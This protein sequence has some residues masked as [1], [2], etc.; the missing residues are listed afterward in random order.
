MARGFSGGLS[1]GRL[2]FLFAVLAAAG[3]RAAWAETSV[4][5][6]DH[7]EIRAD[8][9][10]VSAEAVSRLALVM[11]GRFAEHNR[12]FRFDPARLPGPLVVSVF[13]DPDRYENHV[14]SLTD[15]DVPP[16][17]AY[18]HFARP[19]PRELAVRLGGWE[20]GTPEALP[21]Q[22]FI[23]FL[24]AF[25]PNPP[26]WM[27]DGF[28][29][30]F[31]TLDFNT[32][33]EPV[34]RENL[35]W[36]DQV[37]SMAE[38]PTPDEIMR[39]ADSGE[40]ENFSGLAWSLVSFFLESGDGDYLRSL[41]ESFMALSGSKSAGENAAAVADRVAMWHDMDALAADH[42]AF[43]KSRM[44]FSDLVDEGRRQYGN[45]MPDGAEAAFR[46][47]LEIRPDHH[48][49][50]YYLGLLAY[51][52]GDTETAE[53]FYNRALELGADAA[54][55]TYAIALNAATAGRLDEAR[56][57]LARSA[58]MAPDRFGE[59]AADL[60]DLLDELGKPQ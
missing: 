41:T 37:K 32:E 45:G 26:A 54:A 35:A 10:E 58:D 60:S 14:A 16:G 5:K 55:V 11:E 33:G 59:R 20:T 47:A 24:R 31:A 13:G 38:I 44:S 1:A 40:S 18:L 39:A 42:A 51:N 21:F 49:P 27:R 52:R 53:I 9:S 25:V 15:G 17:A 56:G 3:G 30:Y 19:E 4:L 23:Q 43:L 48:V 29:A 57:L 34:R 28:G 46:A 7:F 2:L 12:I 22:A 36:L 6:T 8:L 50:F